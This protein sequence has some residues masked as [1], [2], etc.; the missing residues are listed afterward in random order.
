MMA[1]ILS[2]V[3]SFFTT[4]FIT[5]YL[6]RFLRAVGVVGLD[7]HKKNKPLLPSSGGICVASG[8]LAGLL[9]YIGINTFVSHTADFN[10]PLLA[11]ISSILLVTFVGLID[12]LNVKSRRRGDIRVGIPQWVK[13]LITL[14]AAIPLM[15]LN[16]GVATMSVPFIGEINFG[17]LYPLILI[18]IAVVGAS[19][20]VNMLGGFNGSESG[21]GIVYFL[22][23]GIFAALKGNFSNIIFLISFAALLAFI[24]YNWTPAKILPGDSLTYL[25]GSVVAAGIIVGNMEKIGVIL[26]IPF[27]IEFL[28][29]LRSRFRAKSTGILA[30]DGTIESRY[31]GRIY[32]LT[33]F[34]MMFGRLKEKQITIALI[35]IELAF[36]ILIFIPGIVY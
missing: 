21:M 22:G 20:M 25:M 35:L 23:L 19:N 5:P 10:M 8:I 9:S 30:K 27:F 13:P 29:K 24:K 34:V 12:D 3:I 31:G 32:S 7:L 28:L 18:P 15:V 2:M 26:M 1:I 16:A 11:T 17:I 14:P 36:T 33:H 4:Y 6:I